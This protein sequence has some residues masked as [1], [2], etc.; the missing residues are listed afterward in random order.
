MNNLEILLI[1]GLM[2]DGHYSKYRRYLS[3]LFE[4]KN[5]VYHKFFKYL[6]Y[7]NETNLESSNDEVSFFSQYP[8]L[9]KDEQELYSDLFKRLNEIEA[10]PEL[11]SLLERFK[12]KGTAVQLAQAALNLAEGKENLEEVYQLS[13]ELLLAQPLARMGETEFISDDLEELLSGQRDG[14]GL[15]WRLK[16]LQQALGP[17]RRGDFGFVFARPE[18]GKTT[19]LASEVG[20]FLNQVDRERPILWF[21]NE[22]QGDKVKVRCIQAFYNI[23]QQD[24]DASSS[25]YKQRWREDCSGKLLIYDSANIERSRVESLV[26]ERNPSL[27]I[28]DQI[29]KIKGFKDDRPDLELGKIYIWAREL[30][31]TYAPVIG[32]CQAGGSAENKMWL[33]MEDVVNAKTSKQAEA[34]WILGIGT[35]HEHANLR[36]L[37][38]SKNK[39]SGGPESVPEYRHG[40]F[41]VLI[42]PM[43]ARY[44]D[45]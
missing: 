20:G 37:H 5:N 8:F 4:D 22:E 33:T 35:V 3:D 28:F 14:T 45:I 24:L 31:K 27:I 15:T 38:I 32:V 43:I 30:A 19:F 2:I 44:E 25:V 40:K 17:L 16:C 42:Q 36:Y 11:D 21:N 10:V 9:K 7:K 29:D 1:K 26:R 6:D 12:K 18:T 13:Q 39:L 41:Q 23:S 34:D